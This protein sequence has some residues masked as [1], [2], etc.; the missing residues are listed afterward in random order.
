MANPRNTRLGF[1]KQ[2]DFPVS[3]YT[4]KLGTM[5]FIRQY[6]KRQLHGVLRKY[7]FTYSQRRLCTKEYSGKLMSQLQAK[8]KFSGPITVADYMR[9]AL[10]HSTEGYYIHR[11][12]FGEKGDFTTSPEISQMFGELVAIWFVNE[13]MMAGSPDKVQLVELGPGRGTMADD[14]LRAISNFPELKT[15]L[16]LHMIEI[17]E[18][19]SQMQEEK[20][21]ST[22][23]NTSNSSSDNQPHYK[24]CVSKHGP[25]VY[26]YRDVQE[27]P[28]GYTMFVAH[29]FFD[30]L[31][32]HKF[33][34]TEKGWREM[35]VDI[36]P[37]QDSELRFV[38]APTESAASK[39][40]L[41]VDPDDSREHI[42]VCPS[43]GVIVQYLAD[44]IQKHGGCALIADYGHDGT[45]DDTFRGFK[46]HELHDVLVDP[47]SADLTADVDFSYLKKQACDKVKVYGP[48]T[49][50]HFL[51]NM[52]IAYRLKILFE[53]ADEQG[54]KDLLSA[55]KIL[56]SPEEMGERFKF[57]AL[58]N[59]NCSHSPVGFDPLP[60]E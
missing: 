35:L 58:V 15:S 13:W 33:Q 28:A 46:N 27:V 60:E 55:F 56:T 38:L 39:I 42:E 59:K 37:G 57:L 22:T 40:Y 14:M 17:S 32:I 2:G 11:D 45:K 16:S 18:K 36:D 47:G 44:R 25:S 19:L 24:S 29:E 1:P 34:K 53:Q 52:G 49:Q 21:S 8:I 9:E 31:P 51:Q 48:V 3:M 26:W 5:Q 43:A 20:L 10:T 12:V 23:D 41:K 30:A 6:C 7:C 54:K 4:C 50:S